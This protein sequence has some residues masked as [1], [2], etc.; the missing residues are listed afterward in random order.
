MS[1][2]MHK[3]AF[4]IAIHMPR[5]AK[6][7]EERDDIGEHRDSDGGDSPGSNIIQAIA[8]MLQTGGKP[9]A[10]AVRGL[11]QCLDRVADAAE[12]KD[13]DEVNRFCGHAAKLLHIM[14]E[15]H[16]GK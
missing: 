14:L 15:G 1:N 11:A 10:E 16:K 9:E 2:P 12:D 6:E 4:A 3:P 13:A 7:D 8:D 5:F